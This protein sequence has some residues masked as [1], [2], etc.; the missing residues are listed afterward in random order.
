VRLELIDRRLH[1]C[2]AAVITTVGT[3]G[4]GPTGGTVVTLSTASPE[5]LANPTD[6]FW[7]GSFVFIIDRSQGGGA[8]SPFLA[9]VATIVSA[10]QIELGAVPETIPDGWTVEAGVDY[11][12]LDPDNSASGSGVSGFNLIEMSMLAD[13]DGVAGTNPDATI[14]P[15]WR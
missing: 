6:S 2:P 10:T 3:I 13:D 7:L 5:S 11:L 8:G 12:V 9:Y 4:A 15:R 14:N 1:I